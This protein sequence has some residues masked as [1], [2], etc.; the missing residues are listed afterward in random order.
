MVGSGIRR[1]WRLTAPAFLRCHIGQAGR[2]SKRLALLAVPVALLA[3]ALLP[4]REPAT[5]LPLPP[6]GT[7]RGYDIAPLNAASGRRDLLVLV[8]FSGGGKR[9]A[10]FAHGVL[11]GMRDVP[12]ALGGPPTTLLAEIDQIAAVSG[13]TFPAA[14][15]ALHG[16][17]SFATFRADFLDHDVE[18]Y[19][20]GTWLLPWNWSW[21]V[22]PYV[23][24]ND[25]M[26][27]VYDRLMFGGATYRD[28][29]ARGRPRLSINATEIAT[30]IPF[31][32]LPQAFDLIC[33]DLGAVPL[34]RAVAASNGFPLLFTPIT[35]ANHRGPG[36]TAALPD[37]LPAA[38]IAADYRLR[39]LADIAA[40]MGDPARTPFIH[41]MD[42]G[43][44]DNLALRAAINI[45]LTGGEPGDD[46]V[47][48]IAPVR[49]VLLISVDGQAATDPSLSRRR[50]VTGLG[51][52]FAAVSGGQIDNYN[53]ETL[54]LAEAE[55][56]R[57]MD[58]LRR[59]RCGL[60]PAAIWR[61]CADV[62]GRL[63]RIALADHP[64]PALRAR[65]QAIPTGLTIPSADVDLL[66]AA[67][68]AMAR[69]HPALRAFL[70]PAAGSD[71]PRQ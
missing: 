10:A 61:G 25:R 28:L 47:G 58:R 59:I 34:A 16:E 67:G 23:G 41:L 26:A 52:I 30:G 13:G 4:A 11:R 5:T 60:V 39:Q 24:T 22:N 49:R 37:P 2:M 7:N 53:L 44:S 9:S 3:L 36:C 8:S 32:F 40:R 21:L 12:V 20:W 18:S 65:L 55:L 42:G 48:M 63:V 57:S 68:E 56:A 35:L 62:E 14:H 38:A 33:A 1:L 70:A 54:A 50:V 71:G 29:F 43:I 45:M 31:P 64:D 17:R 66:V 46:Y 51:Q 6:G 27:Q 15:F 69:D 19:I